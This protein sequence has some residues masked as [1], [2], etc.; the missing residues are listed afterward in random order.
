MLVR[1]GILLLAL[2][3]GCSKQKVVTEDVGLFVGHHDPT[4]NDVRSHIVASLLRY[5]KYYDDSLATMQAH[6]VDAVKVLT[7]EYNASQSSNDW[8]KRWLL[9]H[10]LSKMEHASTI[11]FYRQVLT[12]A[13]PSESS[14]HGELSHGNSPLDHEILIRY[15]ALHGLEALMRKGDLNARALLLETIQT[16]LHDSVLAEAVLAYLEAAVDHDAARQEVAALLPSEKSSLLDL[17][18]IA[19]EEAEIA[20]STLPVSEPVSGPASPR[21]QK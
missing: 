10:T 12:T 6:G 9:L 8:H 3:T 7:D 2:L 18:R 5:T 16:P 17:Q 1:N 4:S 11:D 13:L 19:P 21:G 20:D 14:A 15:G